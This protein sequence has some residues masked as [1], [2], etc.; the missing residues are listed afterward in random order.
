[1]KEGRK[2]GRM[3]FK[4]KNSELLTKETLKHFAYL[5]IQFSWNDNPTVIHKET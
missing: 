2:D 3:N 1:M 5:L 4:R